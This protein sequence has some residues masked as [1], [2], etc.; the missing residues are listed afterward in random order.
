MDGARTSDWM[1]WD[2]Q[3]MQREDPKEGEVGTRGRRR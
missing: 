1:E 2:E 3:R